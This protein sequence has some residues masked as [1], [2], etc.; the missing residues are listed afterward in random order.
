MK[1][2]A[3]RIGTTSYI[4]ADDILP[5]VRYLAPMVDDIELVLFESEQMS[6]LPSRQV[7]EELAA[8]A[9]QHDL[10]YTIHFPLDIFPGSADPLVRRACI[11]SILSI[12]ELTQDLHP[13]AYVLHLTPE[14]YGEV[15]SFEVERWHACLDETLTELLRQTEVSPR[16]FCI[17][18]LS[19]P[20]HYVQDLVVRHDLSI[21][22]DIG[23]VWLMGYD[24]VEVLDSLLRRTR[25]CHLHGVKDKTDH[26]G[27]NEGDAV[28]IEYFLKRLLMQC[29]QDGVK[30][31][32]T[33]EVFSE[34]EFHA[35]LSLL[36][37][38]HAMMN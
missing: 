31:V 25:V 26:L 9:R 6:N 2:H 22:L 35:S 38:S 3:L 18:T 12:I 17:E 33:L 11:S 7:V 4:L 30:R 23:H 5:N 24:S 1:P 32:L 19:Y 13:F 27:L 36:H 37:Q 28:Q 15:P 8:L 20:F 16:M 14:L 29:R 21:T 34:A 10:T